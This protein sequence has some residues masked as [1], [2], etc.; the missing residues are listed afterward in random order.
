MRIHWSTGVWVGGGWHMVN[1]QLHVQTRGRSF[2]IGLS[3]YMRLC[4]SASR[5]RP[6]KG[7]AGRP[8]Q[9]AYPDTPTS[10][11]T[12]E[13][14]EVARRLV[15]I[16]IQLLVFLIVAC[17]LYFIHVCVEDNSLSPFVAL[18]DS[19]NQGSDSDDGLLLQ[20][21]TQDT[22]ALSGQE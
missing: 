6:I 9:Y 17:L 1:C 19:L 4:F 13:R 8:V 3:A 5:R 10:P 15:P 20:A 12:L 21:R 22:P 14:R 18:L 7:A 2:V 16:H 11:T